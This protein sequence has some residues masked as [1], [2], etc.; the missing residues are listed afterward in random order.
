MVMDALQS[1]IAARPFLCHAFIGIGVSTLWL[2]MPSAT[3]FC[4]AKSRQKPL[5]GHPLKTPI[6][7]GDK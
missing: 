3:Y 5:R 1:K 4:A 6:Y 7:E 2:V